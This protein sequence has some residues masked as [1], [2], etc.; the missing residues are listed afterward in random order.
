M[1][2]PVILRTAMGDRPRKEQE[3]TTCMQR[4]GR[5]NLQRGL[6]E[7]RSEQVLVLDLSECGGI[8]FGLQRLRLRR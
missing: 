2:A 8:R 7:L 4:G 1:T 3:R 5:W 6:W